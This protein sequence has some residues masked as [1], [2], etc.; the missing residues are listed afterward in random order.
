MQTSATHPL[1]ILN[2]MDSAYREIIGK[3]TQPTQ[4]ENSTWSGVGFRIGND[5]LVIKNN[6]IDEI[7]N[8][9]FQENLSTVPGAKPWLLG[10]TSLRGQ[11]LSVIDLKQYLFNELS[12]HTNHTRL[13]VIKHNHYLAGL[14]VEHVYG[15][16]QFPLN[17][18]HQK[19]DLKN[20]PHFSR[21]VIPFIDKTFSDHGINR[22]NLSISRLVNN[23]D[24]ANAAR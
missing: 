18:N 20:K 8:T 1:L 6:Y 14:L 12:T 21:E 17:A 5:E 15:L 19:I 24:F 4:T 9:R 2:E 3:T 10:L 7:I 23:P 16:K 13:I 22:G 11:P